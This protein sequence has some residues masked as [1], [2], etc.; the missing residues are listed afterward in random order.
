MS[1]QRE[2]NADPKPIQNIEF[3]GHLKIFDGVKLVVQ[4]QFFT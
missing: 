3:V 4:N 2:L 1:S